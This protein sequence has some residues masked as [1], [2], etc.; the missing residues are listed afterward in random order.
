MYE[1]LLAR[2]GR[3]VVRYRL[4]IPIILFWIALAA[5]MAVRA[6]SL[7]KV[8]VMDESLFL[9]S[10]SSYL[11]AKKILQQKFPDQ[12]ATG[13]GVL[14]FYD[15]HGLSEEDMAY[16]RNLATWLI[17]EGP[18][19]ITRVTSIFDKPELKDVL[20]S[21]DHQAMLMQ[22]AFT[23]AEYDPRTNES[24]AAIRQHVQATAP[25]TLHV[26]LTG[27]AGMG[28][29]MFQVIRESVD[30]TTIATILLVIFVL[31]LVYRSP[32][33]ALVPLISIAA[34]YLTA[35]G[36]LGFAAQAGMKLSS[37]LDAM[38][39][40]LLF[41]VGTDYAL[42]LISRFREEV[43]KGDGS[44]EAMVRTVAKIGP[45]ITASAAT[46]IIGMLGMMVADFGMTRS[47]GP[48]QSFGVFIV[49]LAALSLTPAL[50]QLFGERLFWPFHRS[51]AKQRVGEGLINWKKIGQFVTGHPLLVTLVVL[52]VL[53]LPYPAWFNMRS[54]F[55]ILNEIPKDMDAA[56]GF[57]VIKAHFSAGEFAPVTVI[58]TTPQ[59]GLLQPDA[60]QDIATVTE[61]LSQ[62]EG[63]DK[64]RSIVQPTGDPA[65][66]EMLRVDGQLRSLADQ[67]TQ[68][69]AALEHPEKFGEMAQEGSTPEA[70]FVLLRDYLQ[71]L[72]DAFPQVKSDPAYADA[73]NAVDTL[74]ARMKDMLESVR[75]DNQLTT[76]ADRMDDLAQQMTTPAA[77]AQP[78]A[79]KNSQ[80]G[81]DTLRAYLEDLAATYPEVKDADEYRDA[82][83]ALDAL[84]K[85]MA[86]MRAQM[87]VVNQL[88]GM[89]AQIAQM[90]Q[91]LAN[92]QAMMS[93]GKGEN[94][95]EGLTA[96][97][98]Y[99]QGL[100][101]AYP[102][103]EKDSAYQD[104]LARLQR[105]QKGMHAMQQQA[106][107]ANQLSTLVG[108]LQGLQQML[109]NPQA[110]AQ[111][112]QEGQN[113]TQGLD[114]VVAYL[115]ELGKAYPQ[116]QQAPQYSDAL[117]RV[118]ALKAAF[119]QMAQAQA[120]GTNVPPAQ[121]QAA[122]Q[123]LH[124]D[125][126]ELIADLEVLQKGFAQHPEAVLFPKSLP[127]PA[128]TMQ[129][130]Q[131]LQSDITAL[132]EDVDALALTF[133]QNAPEA[134]YVPVGMMNRP[135]VQQALKQT[136]ARVHALADALR[137]LAVRFQGK[138][139]YFIPASM[140]ETGEAAQM[141]DEVKV[142][143]ERL[144]NSLNALADRFAGEKAY[145]VPQAFLK[146]TP[147]LKQLLD[148]Y[149]SKDGTATQM[150]VLLTGDPYSVQTADVIDALK[151]RLNDVTSQV[152]AD[153]DRH[154]TGYI[155][156]VPVMSHD[157]KRTVARDFGK[158]QAVVVAGVFLVFVLLLRS[159][160]API[161]L[162]LT[163]VLNYG[164]TMGLVTLIFQ[165]GLGQEGVNYIMPLFI[166]V[167]LVALGADY[168]IF[169][170]SRVQEEAEKAGDVREGIRLASMYTGG[171]ITSCGIILAGTFAALAVSPFR[172]LVQMGVAVA[173]GVILDTF[174]VRTL[175]V[176]A[177]ATLLDKWNWWPRRG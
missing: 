61:A 166:F 58:L 28:H 162:V 93:K 41:G 155:G 129:A 77:L 100:A 31:L 123:A 63:V 167:L 127:T 56:R 21:K 25:E 151:A 156:G 16:A 70:A 13:Q 168:N 62:V 86:E 35:R 117:K 40:V 10:D 71:E 130:M 103:L 119:A 146:R 136:Q 87:L 42:F 126:D 39:V 164:T 57:Q 101:R 137:G 12:V 80:A 131:Q 141:L 89:S 48:A 134:T 4:W 144:K 142:E 121:Q 53:L 118:D 68:V 104:A 105:I 83:S 148:V 1:R 55:N 22:V 18:E 29:D 36:I 138:A 96:L 37:M 114:L 165:E 95:A 172:M 81:F 72:G 24:V 73:L 163:V 32:V 116:V 30:K 6:P 75:V 52:V 65:D 109:A 133:A 34:A 110:L 46:V 92:P 122:L 157:L 11:Q 106:S 91:A 66:S 112:S 20:V 173:I 94:P 49:L 44:A 161:Y 135:E 85:S 154:Y 99:L 17:Q 43:S 64:V 97:V 98:D 149:I 45:V 82:L 50:L 107:V 115:N 176:P 33:A 153:N 177:I 175:L 88:K 19:N 3:V 8:G 47:N 143:V 60:L 147:Q 125:L 171:I 84:Q 124:K 140:A 111:A 170:M 23:T 90:K 67:L 14:V 54:S 38:I 169:L 27:P 76:M 26:Y 59:D 79:G 160:I 120:A 7:T 69:Q 145:F 132:A 5:F 9:P 128:E 174:V 51:L 74:Q 113:P 159:L 158:V 108:R 15:A 150:T 2:V 102:D 139:A 152:G 78:Q